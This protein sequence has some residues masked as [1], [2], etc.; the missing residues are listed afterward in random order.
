MPQAE[1]DSPTCPT[2]VAFHWPPNA[3]GEK[4]RETLTRMPLQRLTYLL[5]SQFPAVE[6]EQ[7]GK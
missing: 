2:M 1:E 5:L 6:N 7:K 3:Y 4:T